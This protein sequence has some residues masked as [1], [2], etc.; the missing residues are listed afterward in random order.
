MSLCRICLE[1]EEA[2]KYLRIHANNSK[3]SLRIFHISGVQVCDKFFISFV[4]FY[5]LDYL[6]DSGMW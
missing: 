6:L 1:P 5:Y 4:D 2:E 3:V